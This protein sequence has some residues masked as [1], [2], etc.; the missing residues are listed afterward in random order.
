MTVTAALS[1]ILW[2]SAGI[3]GAGFALAASDTSPRPWYTVALAFYAAVLYG[4]IWLT[5][6]LLWTDGGRYGWRFTAK[7]AGEDARSPWIV[8]SRKEC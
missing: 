7:P 4:P 3:V 5:I 2:V 8:P 1:L 6:T